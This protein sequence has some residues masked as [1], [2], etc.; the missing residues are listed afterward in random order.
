MN[1]IFR[2][3]TYTII[4]FCVTPTLS[5]RTIKSPE[6]LSV[7]NIHADKLG[8]S[9]STL[10][11]DLFF[12][13]PNGLSVELRKTD[14]DI[15]VNQSLLGHSAQVLK[16]KVPR[17]AKFKMPLTLQVDMKSLL[18]T[19]LSTQLKKSSSIKVVG[20]VYLVKG[21][22]VKKISVD[23]TTERELSFFN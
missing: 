9:G 17:K 7:E 19:G 1:K 10:S 20:D 14:L 8:F 13:N 6:F 23:Y 21:G 22:I 3:L 2:F 18:K 16:L 5:C 11:A 4:F 12:Y 15:Y